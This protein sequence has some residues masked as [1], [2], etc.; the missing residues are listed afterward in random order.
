[1]LHFFHTA[2][3]PCCAFSCSYLVM[4]L[5]FLVALFLC[6]ALFHVALFY[7]LQCFCFPFLHV[8]MS[9]P[10]AHLVVALCSCCT[11]SR[12][13]ARTTINI[14]RG[15]T[16]QQQY[17]K[18]LNI[19]TKLS[20]VDTCGVLAT[21]LLFPCFTFTM[22]RFFMFY[23]FHVAFFPWCTFFSMWYFFFI[24]LFSSCIFFMLHFFNVEKY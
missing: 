17:I 9:S 20:I 4:F 11:I 21:L 15:R 24:A 10:V 12:G 18:P 19:V 14:P 1:M 8:A 5:F 2:P 16:L 6:T 3:L 7:M 13:V 22:S 23:F